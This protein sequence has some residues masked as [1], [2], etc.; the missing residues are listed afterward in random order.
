MQFRIILEKLILYV[1]NNNIKLPIEKEIENLV[2]GIS[3]PKK[4]VFYPIKRDESCINTNV[5]F[6]LR[7]LNQY[8]F[9]SYKMKSIFVFKIEDVFKIYKLLLLEKPILFFNENKEKLTNIFESFLSLIYSFEYQNPH[10]AI[11][12]DCN[13]GL[14]EQ[15]KSFVFGINEKWVEHN[16][17]KMKIILKD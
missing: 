11:L 14:V 8:N 9:Y 6:L 17:G 10:F 3:F 16:D 1:E 2:L 15:A 5:D 7:D 12:P 4:C 13:A